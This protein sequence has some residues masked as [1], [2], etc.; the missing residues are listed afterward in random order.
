M[1]I[2]TQLVLALF[3]LAV[4]P[5]AGIVLYSYVSSRQAVRAAVE[6]DAAELTREMEERVAEIGADLNRR[7]ERVG[8]MPVWRG[9]TEET[10]KRDS[11]VG[12]VISELGEV[13]PLLRSLE[14]VPAEAPAPAAM[15]EPDARPLAVPTPPPP[16]P[17]R[18]TAW[19]IDF[20]K[21]VDSLEKEM[22]V[23][24][25]QALR[26]RILSGLKIGA[27]E[28]HQFS[29]EMAKDFELDAEDLEAADPGDRAPPGRGRGAPG[30]AARP[31]ARTA[32]P[33]HGV[34][35]RVPAPPRAGLQ[36]CRGAGAGGGADPRARRGGRQ[37]P[38][39]DQPGRDPP[40]G[41]QPHPHETR[42]RSRSPSTRPAT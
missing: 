17:R 5:L 36:P 22:E 4:V 20:S 2:R 28:A 38:R 32:G 13:A 37:V 21:A 25:P 19:V 16:P 27:K 33:R 26:K 12:M 41:A 30:A 6:Q 15:V 40:P 1:K 31:G 3:L 18:P 35:P 11:A 10:D 24:L 29:L 39:P 7:F 8:A 14:F 34:A 9:L 23:E 42:A